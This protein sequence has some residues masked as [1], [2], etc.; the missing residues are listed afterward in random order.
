MVGRFS[1]NW[2]GYEWVRRDGK[3]DGKREEE[4]EKEDVVLRI[5]RGG[6]GDDPNEEMEDV[7]EELEPCIY[8]GTG[9][10]EDTDTARRQRY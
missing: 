7:F 3:R 10:L 2:D 8:L 1:W 6:V 9:V 4:V 5:E